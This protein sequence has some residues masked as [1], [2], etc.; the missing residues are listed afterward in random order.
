[1]VP[2]RAGMEWLGIDPE[3]HIGVAQRLQKELPNAHILDQYSN[4]NN[5]DAHYNGTAE[6]I[7]EDI[8]S[9]FHVYEKPN[10]NS[11]EFE[12]VSEKKK[13]IVSEDRGQDQEINKI[14]G[15]SLDSVH[16]WSTMYGCG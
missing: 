7:L 14:W 3:S 11:L 1:M 4:A 6:E 9:A 2:D 15:L 12:T 8:I 5:P 16:H 13:K 10:S